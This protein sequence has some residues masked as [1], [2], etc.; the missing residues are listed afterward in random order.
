VDDKRQAMIIL[1]AFLSILVTVLLARVLPKQ[2]VNALA[3]AGLAV[4]AVGFGILGFAPYLNQEVAARVSLHP[5]L[6]TVLTWFFFV[7]SASLL[8]I[9]LLVRI[10]K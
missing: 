3:L 9:S 5:Y 7:V 8:V 10:R 2:Y 4:A 6:I 1:L